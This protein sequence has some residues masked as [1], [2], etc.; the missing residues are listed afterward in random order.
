MLLKYTYWNLYNARGTN[1]DGVNYGATNLLVAMFLQFQC[2]QQPKILRLSYL[3]AVCHSAKYTS[4]VGAD[5]QQALLLL[6]AE[7]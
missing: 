2:C 3:M 1:N 4:K 7:I 6:Y 5:L